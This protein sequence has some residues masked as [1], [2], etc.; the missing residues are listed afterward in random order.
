MNTALSFNPFLL[1]KIE[2]V[3]TDVEVKLSSVKRL[4]KAISTIFPLNVNY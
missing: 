1:N 3:N 4:N 2:D